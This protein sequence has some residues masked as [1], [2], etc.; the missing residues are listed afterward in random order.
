M[1]AKTMTEMWALLDV[2]TLTPNGSERDVN[3]Q[4]EWGGFSRRLGMPVFTGW[5]DMTEYDK[6][7]KTSKALVCD[8]D[9][10]R[11]IGLNN[12]ERWLKFAENSESGLAAFFVIHAVDQK[13]ELR[14]YP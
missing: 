2:Y 11:P 13:A 4:N 6:A 3:P 5:K 12:Q 14:S 10:S 1:A 8:T 9:W 7:A